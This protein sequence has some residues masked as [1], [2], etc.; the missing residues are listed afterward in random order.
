MKVLKRYSDSP[1]LES[2]RRDIDHFF[3][4]LVP[5]AWRKENG[6]RKMEL[7]APDSDLRETESEYVITIDLPGTSKKDIEVGYKDNRLTISGQREKEEKK[8]YIRRERYSGQF[9]RSFTLPSAVKDDNIK[10]SFKDGVL[11]VKVPKAEVSKPK[12]V[13]ID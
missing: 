7:W 9:L 3:D 11:T 10:A 5:F 13:Q 1:A 4:D 6:G 2:I 8:D 12:T